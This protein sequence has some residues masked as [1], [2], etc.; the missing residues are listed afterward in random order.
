MGRWR[1]GEMDTWGERAID[2]EVETWKHGDTERERQRCRRLEMWR[3]GVLER[4]RDAPG[5]TVPL[6]FVLSPTSPPVHLPPQLRE[7]VFATISLMVGRA[8][9]AGAQH[10][11][12]AWG[13]DRTLEWG[14][15]GAGWD[16]VHHCCPAFPWAWA[17][18]VLGPDRVQGP[19]A[20]LSPPPAP[21]PHG[22]LYTVTRAP[23]VPTKTQHCP[24][25][26]GP[27]ADSLGWLYHL[28]A[29]V[30]AGGAGMKDGYSW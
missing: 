1:D 21:G 18:P 8:A 20:R 3:G 14:Q 4:W 25:P 28:H 10:D 7:E 12:A 30:S 17:P 27:T 22:P 16:D 11:G 26:R 29:S 5:P 24:T 13:R 19:W 6:C 15:A 2:G 9:G 23:K